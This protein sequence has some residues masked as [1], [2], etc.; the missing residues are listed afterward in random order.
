MGI[1]P[2]RPHSKAD[3]TGPDQRDHW[4]QC[5]RQA[6]VAQPFC[7]PFEL[8]QSLTHALDLLRYQFPQREAPDAIAESGK[9]RSQ[10]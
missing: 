1:G 4:K 8:S 9:Q 5:K 2:Q 7:D 10:T 6:T 3:A